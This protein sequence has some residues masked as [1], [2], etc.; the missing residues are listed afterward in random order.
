MQSSNGSLTRWPTAGLAAVLV[1]FACTI[2]VIRATPA[3]AAA[4]EECV[5][6]VAASEDRF[7]D[8]MH[9]G[10]MAAGKEFGYRIFFRESTQE[11]SAAT[12]REVLQELLSFHCTGVLL[13]PSHPDQREAIGELLAA[14]VVMVFVDRGLPGMKGIPLVATDNHAAGRFAAR[15][16]TALLP[17]QQKNLAVFR[18][19]TD[20]PTTTAREEGFIA[21]AS[22]LGYKVVLDTYAGTRV[23]DIRF[24]VPEALQAQKLPI[25]GVFAPNET[26]TVGVA[27]GILAARLKH[28]PVMVGFDA[29]QHIQT[30]IERGEIAGTVLQKPYEMGYQGVQLIHDHLENGQKPRSIVT[31]VEF[32]SAE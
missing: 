30:A 13:A 5:G 9:E 4:D 1:A 10:A 15:K 24:A 20:V 25:H 8:Q 12:R 22:A 3:L 31:G 28:P 29:N 32:L 19:D 17:P 16:L 7:W 21:E 14:G 27:E 18:L 6:L 23:G 26:T 2:T 11:E